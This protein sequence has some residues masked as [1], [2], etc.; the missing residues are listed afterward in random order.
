MSLARNSALKNDDWLILPGGRSG[1]RATNLFWLVLSLAR[2]GWNKRAPLFFLRGGRNRAIILE[3]RRG[4]S[5][6]A[7]ENGGEGS[8]VM[9]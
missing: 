5:E 9:R 1:S 7:K 2:C 4:K 3:Q 8:G 6:A